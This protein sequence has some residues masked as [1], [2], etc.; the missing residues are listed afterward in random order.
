MNKQS[1]D[2][3]RAFI[4]AIVAERRPQLFHKIIG[5]ENL[6]TINPADMDEL[7]DV[8]ADFDSAFGYIEGG[9]PTCLADPVESAIG[10]L[11]GFIE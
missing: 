4:L 7:Q 5:A 1:L 10:Y 3:R 2:Y 11:N 6:R 8:L 9:V